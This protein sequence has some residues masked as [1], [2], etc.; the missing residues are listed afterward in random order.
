MI[1]TRLAEASRRLGRLLEDVERDRDQLVT[2]SLTLRFV[3]HQAGHPHPGQL[4]ELGYVRGEWWGAGHFF[5]QMDLPTHL[6]PTS[7]NCRIYL[8]GGDAGICDTFIRYC[9]EA[10]AIFCRMA[11]DGTRFNWAK[12]LFDTFQDAVDEKGR[13]A[14]EWRENEEP[15]QPETWSYVAELS[16]VFEWTRI[17]LKTFRDGAELRQQT[18]VASPDDAQLGGK[19]ILR[20][21]SAAHRK[22]VSLLDAAKEVSEGN[23]AVAQETK[24]RWQGTEGRPPRIGYDQNHCQTELFEVGPL[25]DWIFSMS[26]NG[27]HTKKSLKESMN[28]IRRACLEEC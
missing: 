1:K 11:G 9:R 24:K 28:R 5:G 6:G 18:H 27:S 19:P 10:E 23:N 2:N 22:G 8:V 21:A 20:P 26:E 16:D 15:G 17:L 13:D 14:V 3:W 7:Y 12:E 4:W 25:V